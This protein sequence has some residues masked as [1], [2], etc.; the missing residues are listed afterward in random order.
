M[1]T[2]SSKLNGYMGA[3]L[4]SV[5]K[6]F[7]SS[8]NVTVAMAS[9]DDYPEMNNMAGRLDSNDIV[10]HC[11]FGGKPIQCIPTELFKLLMMI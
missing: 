10:T 5:F 6:N 1:L 2:T 11:Y 4:K 3:Y 7:H 8:Y 9:L